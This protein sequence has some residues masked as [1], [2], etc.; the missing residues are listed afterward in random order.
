MSLFEKKQQISRSEFRESLRK[1]SSS[2]PG[3]GIYSKEDRVKIEKELFP[4]NRYRGYI[5]KKELG[6]CIQGL[7]HEKYLAKTEKEKIRVDRQIRYL[8]KIGGI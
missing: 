1:S 8:K 6:K 7:G 4:E 5:S 3:G 2:V